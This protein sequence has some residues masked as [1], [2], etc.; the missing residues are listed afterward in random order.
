M[1]WVFLPFRRYFDFS[2]RSR[3]MEYW[4][5]T[6]FTFIVTI[7]LIAPIVVDVID[8]LAAPDYL[9]GPVPVGEPWEGIG[10]LSWVSIWLL[11]LFVLVTFIPG[12]AVTVRRFHDV[13]L[14]GWVYVALYVGGLIFGIVG[15]AIFVIALLPSK[16]GTNKWGR[17]PKDPHGAEVFE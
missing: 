4:A 17:N 5:F 7:C 2:G 3:R 6:L 9:D 12:L 8:I 15:L 16:E 11:G 13:G 1:N 14:S 10:T